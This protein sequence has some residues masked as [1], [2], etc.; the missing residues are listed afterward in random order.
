MFNLDESAFMLVPKDNEVITEKG[1]KA[2][3][4][5]ASS[6]ENAS[7]TALFT[8]SATGVIPPPMILFDLKTTPKENVWIKSQKA[9]K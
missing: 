5:I 3:Y 7:I 6:N 1:T 9:G 2:P 4:Q 8:T